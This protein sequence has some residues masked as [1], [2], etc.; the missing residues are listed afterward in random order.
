MDSNQTICHHLDKLHSTPG[1]E[2]LMDIP[3]YANMQECTTGFYFNVTMRVT[4]ISLS[5]VLN[6]VLNVMTSDTRSRTSNWYTLC[7]PYKEH[8]EDDLIKIKYFC[9]CQQFCYLRL[10]IRA[11]LYPTSNFELCFAKIYW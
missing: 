2:F 10:Q 6:N 9:K 5:E 8:V 11:P 4:N 1:H 3:Y 7:T